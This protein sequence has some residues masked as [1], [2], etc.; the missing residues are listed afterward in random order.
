MQER[1]YPE[2]EPKEKSLVDIRTLLRQIQQ[3]IESAEWNGKP[4]DS[5]RLEYDH[6]KKYHMQTGSHYYPL[7]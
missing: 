7:F 4:C 2:P 3:E 6:V 5:I 1:S